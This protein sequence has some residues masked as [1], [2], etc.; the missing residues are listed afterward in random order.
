MPSGQ[1]PQGGPDEQ[2]LGLGPHSELTAG[3]EAPEGGPGTGQLGGPS[4]NK[5]LPQEN[6]GP[7]SFIG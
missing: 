3:Q 2:H 4:Q 6:S 5:D 1:G 7:G